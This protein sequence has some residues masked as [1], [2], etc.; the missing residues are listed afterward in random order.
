MLKVLQWAIVLFN[1]IAIGVM[2]CSGRLKDFFKSAANFFQGISRIANG[3]RKSGGFVRLRCCLAVPSALA[4]LSL[5]ALIEVAF[6][7][8]LG[9]EE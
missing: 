7:R 8:R 6:R 4:C 2:R 3:V 1:I 5:L 9:S